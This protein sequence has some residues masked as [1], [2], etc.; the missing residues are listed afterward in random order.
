VDVEM[1][2]S[3]NAGILVEPIEGLTIGLAWRGANRTYLSIPVGVTLSEQIAPVNIEVLAYD[4]STPHELSLGL[5]WRT[6]PWLVTGDFTYYFYRDFRQSAPTVNMLDS[7]G[8]VTTS[9]EV[10]DAGFNDAVA[11]RLGGEWDPVEGLAVR[12]G[13]A[14]TQTPVPPQAGETNLLDGDRFTASAGLGYD[15]TSLGAPVILDAHVAWAG[16]V[17]NRDEKAA[18]LPENPGYPAVAGSGSVLNAGMTARV[19]F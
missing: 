4:Y 18:F 5:A 17:G 11:V 10:P 2:L 1:H 15:F 9:T 14:W 16:M 6:G 12:L 7:K 8:S 13:F 3:A 19:R